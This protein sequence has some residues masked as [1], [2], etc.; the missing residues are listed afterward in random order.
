[1]LGTLI[2]IAIVL[3]AAVLVYHAGVF[4]AQRASGGAG[5]SVSGASVQAFPGGT[6]V[7]LTVTNTGSAPGYVSVALYHGGSQVFW[8]P[9]APGLLYQIYYDPNQWFQP[10]ANLV[11]AASL[12]PGT[13]FSSGG[14]TWTATVGPWTT[15]GA[16]SAQDVD[17]QTQQN[18][19]DNLQCCYPGGAPFPNP[20]VANGGNSY[21]VKEIGYMVVTQP[22]VFYVDIDDGGI[23]GA[24]P[25]SP[26][27]FPQETAW[28]GGTSNPANLI[29]Q[30]RGEGATGYSSGTVQPG[31]YLVEYDYFNGGGPAYWSLWSNEPVQYYRPV[32]L[33]P[34]QAAT[35]NYTLA[36][37]LA[38]GSQC[39]VSAAIA[40]P[41]GTAVSS[42]TVAAAP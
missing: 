12:S 35:L 25:Y 19:I 31:T 28:L 13:A 27:A 15:P 23:L 34:G 39:T 20:P 3:V 11:Y 18:V 26:G 38:P 32:L 9:G 14:Q 1:M 17:G 2:L 29:N 8:A 42:A 37:Q 24:V 4:A 30:W 16:G 5:I 6:F 7:T 40:T 33:Y 41:A 36:A 10:P 21:A 22:T